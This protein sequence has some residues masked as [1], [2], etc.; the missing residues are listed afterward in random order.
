[1]RRASDEE[2]RLR[3]WIC[4][5]LDDDR[6]NH[7]VASLWDPNFQVEVDL[8]RYR[9]LEHPPASLQYLRLL[10]MV[11]KYRITTPKPVPS[12]YDSTL[13]VAGGVGPHGWAGSHTPN[14]RYSVPA[15]FWSSKTAFHTAARNI[16]R[17]CRHYQ[18]G[19]QPTLAEL[20]QVTMEV[21]S[22]LRSRGHFVGWVSL[23]EGLPFIVASASKTFN[24]AFRDSPNATYAECIRG[25]MGHQL[26]FY[27]KS[28]S[29]RPIVSA[30]GV[31]NPQYIPNRHVLGDDNRAT[32][33]QWF[34][35]PGIP[36]KL[37][38]L[39]QERAAFLEQ[40]KRE[41]ALTTAHRA[42]REDALKKEHE[43]AQAAFIDWRRTPFVDPTG[44]TTRGRYRCRREPS[45]RRETLK[46][47]TARRW[48]VGSHIGT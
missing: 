12:P 7:T 44:Y 36:G 47:I 22:E 48:L 2:A 30:G 34:A 4:W 29:V 26:S 20:Y 18:F 10:E 42:R 21:R 35:Q 24:A 33:S 37:A 46:G 40:W 31:L 9:R 32:V 3:A 27:C 41:R 5:E 19:A 39:W 25:G 8:H 6:I 28:R 38:Q 14:N 1:M 45:L 13:A 11:A 23:H 16:V 15:L 43:A 17:A